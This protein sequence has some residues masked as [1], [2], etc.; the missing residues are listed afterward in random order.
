MQLS[1][2]R[3]GLSRGSCFA[4]LQH[5]DWKFPDAW[6]CCFAYCPVLYSYSCKA[7]A[8]RTDTHTHIQTHTHIHTHARTHT[9]LHPPLI[10]LTP[11]TCRW[12]NHCAF[13]ACLCLETTRSGFRWCCGCSGTSWCSALAAGALLCSVAAQSVFIDDLASL[14]EL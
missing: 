10:P 4:E 2:L 11:L 5:V 12:S 14:N 13:L 1:L 9:P 3:S 8:R 7:R 6:K